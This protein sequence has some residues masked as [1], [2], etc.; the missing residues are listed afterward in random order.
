MSAVPRQPGDGYAGLRM[1]AAEYCSIGETPDRYELID[2]V[3]SMSPRPGSRHQAFLWALVQQI[4]P[5]AE[6]SGARFFP[7]VELVLNDRT[8][9]TPDLM[10]FAPGRVMGSPC[11]WNRRRTSLPRCSRRAT[12]SLT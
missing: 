4:A 12:R 5:Y 11:G 9:Y 6:R 1:T 10:C 7:E 3:V 2:G 8:V